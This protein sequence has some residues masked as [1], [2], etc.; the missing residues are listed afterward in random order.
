MHSDLTFQ[1]RI[2]TPCYHKGFLENLGRQVWWCGTLIPYQGLYYIVL[3]TRGYSLF[4]FWAFCW[5]WFTWGGG[6]LTLVL[7]STL[8]MY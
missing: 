4:C 6:R 5:G 8:M 3:A 1:M 2:Q 7:A